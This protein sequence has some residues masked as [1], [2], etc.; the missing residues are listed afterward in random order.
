MEVINRSN[1]VD[2]IDIFNRYDDNSQ[3]FFK[4]ST[5]YSLKSTDLYDF[6]NNHFVVNK[7]DQL[8]ITKMN[9]ESIIIQPE[10]II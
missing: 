1:N 2:I 5:K 3:S 10:S 6:K 9:L 8:K 4:D 7:D